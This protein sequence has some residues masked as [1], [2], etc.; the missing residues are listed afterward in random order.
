MLSYRCI[1]IVLYICY[2]P[3]VYWS[4]KHNN[5]TTILPVYACIID[6]KLYYNAIQ[7]SRHIVEG[8]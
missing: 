1:L 3:I 5:P 6:D 7:G 2:K 8:G 4:Y